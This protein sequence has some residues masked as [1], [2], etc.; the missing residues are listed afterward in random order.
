MSVV[1]S[2]R[3]DPA[4]GAGAESSGR[5]VLRGEIPPADLRRARTSIST[6]CADRCSSDG[7]HPHSRPQCRLISASVVGGAPLGRVKQCT[8]AMSRT[9]R[10]RRSLTLKV[11]ENRRSPCVGTPSRP[12]GHQGGHTATG[13]EEITNSKLGTRGLGLAAGAAAMLTV[14]RLPPAQ[15]PRRRQPP[16]RTTPSPSATTAATIGS[17]CVWQQVATGTLQVDFGDDDSPKTATTSSARP[18]QRGA[19]TTRP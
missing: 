16:P 5:V 18:G 3:N 19:F 1:A 14:G 11:P 4:R 2:R 7:S 17:R 15:L 8:V 13:E 9:L 12:R 10:A 6:G